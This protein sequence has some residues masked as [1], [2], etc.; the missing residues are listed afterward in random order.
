MSSKTRKV[1]V[2]TLTQNGFSVK[3]AKKYENAI[4]VMCK[5]IGEEDSLDFSEDVYPKY[6]YQKVGQ[7]ITSDSPETILEDINNAIV[8]WSSS[9]YGI[10][11]EE[12]SKT[13][14]LLVEKPKLQKGGFPCNKME[15][16]GRKNKNTIWY[17]L[18]TRSGD[19]GMTTF[20]TCLDCGNRYTIG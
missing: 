19:E 5:K 11:A 1:I 4:F 8:G 6:A 10:Y 14:K 2:Q 7:L 17:Q 12:M 13:R 16:K 18:Q 9:I 3:D 20:I 15:C